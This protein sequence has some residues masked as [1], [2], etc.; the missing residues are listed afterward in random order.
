[1]RINVRISKKAYLVLS[2]RAKKEGRTL[3]AVIDSIVL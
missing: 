1:M 2:K 3:I